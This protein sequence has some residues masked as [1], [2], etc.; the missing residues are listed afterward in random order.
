MQQ[1][2]AS[3]WQWFGILAVAGCGGLQQAPTDTANGSYDAV[4]HGRQMVVQH[5]CGACHGG[6][7]NPAAPGWLAGAR[8]AS[9]T[10]MVGPFKTYPRNLTRMRVEPVVT[11][12]GRSS[13][14]S[15]SVCCFPMRR[16]Q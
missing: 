11:A 7:Q 9:D 15:A 8:S 14:Q 2:R 6:G 5:D 1:W 16:T 4:Q 3:H 13:M 12:S 10:L